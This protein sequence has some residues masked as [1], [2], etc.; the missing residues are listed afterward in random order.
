MAEGKVARAKKELNISEDAAKRLSYRSRTS[1]ELAL[2][3]EDKGFDSELIKSTIEEFKDIGYLDDERFSRDYFRYAAAK[4]WAKSRAKR[5][6]KRKG[7]SDDVIESAYN[8]YLEEFGE[9]DDRAALEIAKKMITSDMLDERGRIIEKYKARVARRLFN[10][11]YGT[12]TIYAAINQALSE[13]N[14]D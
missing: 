13:L 5:E 7:V 8:D 12:S 14:A 2:Y 9:T 4:G 11:G 1:H 6:L 3:L 10:Y